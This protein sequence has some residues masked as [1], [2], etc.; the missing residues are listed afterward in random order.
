MMLRDQRQKRGTDRGTRAHPI[1]FSEE[2][3]TLLGKDDSEWLAGLIVNPPEPNEALKKLMQ[4][5]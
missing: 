2:V 4:K 3:A 5:E 1:P